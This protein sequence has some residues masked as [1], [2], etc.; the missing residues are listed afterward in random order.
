MPSG[1]QTAHALNFLIILYFKSKQ[2]AKVFL[3]VQ[4]CAWIIVNGKINTND[5]LQRKRPKYCLSPQ[6]C[7]MYKDDCKNVDHLFLPRP[8]ALLFWNK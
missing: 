8:V 6:W 7:V 1:L 2:K 3:K 4:I 5:A